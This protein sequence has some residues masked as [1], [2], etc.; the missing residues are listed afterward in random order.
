MPIFGPISHSNLVRNL[1]A[2]GFEGPYAGGKH[3][4][5]VRDELRLTIP[6]PHKG[7][8]RPALLARILRQAEI[9]REEWEA[10]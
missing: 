1:K 6:N 2:L 7:D 8:I 4:F 10:L 5:M 9:S 3:L